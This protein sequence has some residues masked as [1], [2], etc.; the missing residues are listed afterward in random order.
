MHHNSIVLLS[1]TLRISTSLFIE[2][3]LT[4]CLSTPCEYIVVILAWITCFKARLLLAL[5]LELGVHTIELLQLQLEI[6]I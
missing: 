3:W 1:V 5:N 4:T 6:V 2:H